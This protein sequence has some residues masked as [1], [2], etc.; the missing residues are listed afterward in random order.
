LCDVKYELSVTVDKQKAG[1]ALKGGLKKFEELIS[2]LTQEEIA[3]I[4]EHHGLISIK[5]TDIDCSL[6]SVTKKIA[7]TISYKYM[8]DN[9][10]GITVQVD[11]TWDQQL[12][13]KYIARLIA[14]SFQE[15]RKSEGYHV[16]DNVIIHCE[17]SIKCLHIGRIIEKHNDDI[18]KIT[19]VPIIIIDAGSNIQYTH[20]KDIVI[21]DNMLV[22]YLTKL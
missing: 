4:H 8:S 3:M 11:I 7:Q 22:I 14:K 5:N 16:S 13:E 19:Q 1:R 6:L 2:S 15:F 9:T 17:I 10:M 21:A 20:K 12:E 18:V